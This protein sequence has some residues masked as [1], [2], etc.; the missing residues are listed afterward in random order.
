[1]KK[2]IFWGMLIICAT[3]FSGCNQSKRFGDISDP[4][5]LTSLQVT[6][7]STSGFYSTCYPELDLS[8]IE[9]LPVYHASRI[10][11]ETRLEQ[12]EKKIPGIF[13]NS[14][15][16]IE[17]QNNSYSNESGSF[18]V[19]F[20][21]NCDWIYF[22]NAEQSKTFF[23]EVGLRLPEKDIAKYN[24]KTGELTINE[25]KIQTLIQEC[26]GMAVQLRNADFCLGDYSVRREGLWNDKKNIIHANYSITISYTNAY[27]E[28]TKDRLLNYYNLYD[29]IDFIFSFQ[30][31]DIFDF[32]IKS[33]TVENLYLVDDY[34]IISPEKSIERFDDNINV[35]FSYDKIDEKVTFNADTESIK[36]YSIYIIYVCDKENFI[37][38]IYSKQDY[39]FVGNFF[40]AAWIDAIKY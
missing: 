34:G 37:R 32:K 22:R 23:E 16:L 40:G 13:Y 39:R 20:D 4:S 3:F 19:G 35:Y 29:R 12:L 8:D 24:E 1:M 14:L 28:T 31:D 9:K 30:H 21:N 38:P 18:C 6:G 25:K 36:D 11:C 33:Y 10:D 15:N 26:E 2:V 7:F 5:S 17:S 27:P